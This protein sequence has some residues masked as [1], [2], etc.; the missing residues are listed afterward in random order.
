MDTQIDLNIEENPENCEI[1]IS[2]KST[3]VN[4]YWLGIFSLSLTLFTMLFSL[5]SFV[6][7]LQFFPCTK[8]D[9]TPNAKREMSDSGSPLVRMLRISAQSN[10]L[11]ITLAHV[12]FYIF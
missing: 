1:L 5:A 8:F 7:F 9:G 2:L 4:V 12:I 3:T 6:L 11:L 10:L